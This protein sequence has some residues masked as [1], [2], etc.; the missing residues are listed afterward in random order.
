MGRRWGSE[1]EREEEDEF[2]VEVHVLL[3]GAFLQ[4][5]VG[6]IALDPPK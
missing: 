1:G 4:Q 6:N 5:A 3:P 2:E